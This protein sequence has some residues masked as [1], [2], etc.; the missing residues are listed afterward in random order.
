MARAKIWTDEQYMGYPIQKFDDGCREE[1][2]SAIVNIFHFMWTYCGKRLFV[3]HL[4]VFLPED[5]NKNG[6]GIIR[7]A[8]HS[9]RSA[10]LHRKIRAEYLWCREEGDSSKLGRPHYHI[11][12]IVSGKYIQSS[13]GICNDLNRLLSYRTGEESQKAHI[14]PPAKDGFRW[15]KKV[16][17]KLDNLDDAIHWASYL[18]KVS[19]KNAPYRQRTYDYS[20]GFRNH[21]SGSIATYTL[22]E[23]KMFDELDLAISEQD[24]EAWGPENY[25][26]EKELNFDPRTGGPF[27]PEPQETPS[28]AQKIQENLPYGLTSRTSFLRLDNTATGIG[29]GPV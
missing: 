3:S 16:S 10:K 29:H 15:G 24:W 19:T 5:F 6:T 20:R 13:Y 25:D 17:E 21:P 4:T 8:L 2:L 28:P 27:H 18:A 1:I 26:F 14:N 11:F 22:Q 7:N 23:E 9:W 12:L